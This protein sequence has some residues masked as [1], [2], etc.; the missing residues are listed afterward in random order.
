LAGFRYQQIGWV[1]VDLWRGFMM[2]TTIPG[3]WLSDKA[4]ERVCIALGHGSACLARCSF[5]LTDPRWQQWMYY[6]LVGVWL[7]WARVFLDPCVS[8]ADQQGSAAEKCA[9]WRSVCSAPVWV[10]SPCPPRGSVDSCGS[11]LARRFRFT[12]SLRS[13]YVIGDSDLDQIQTSQRPKKVTEE[14]A[15]ENLSV[16]YRLK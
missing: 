8:V 6:L 13:F 9:A 5:W 15:D 12:V 16:C 14:S 7:A 3:G 11:V 1:T 10:F 4:G 2:A